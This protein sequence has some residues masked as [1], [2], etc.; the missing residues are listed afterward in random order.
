MRVVYYSHTAFFES[1]LS[2]VREL[3]R[4][5]EVH[6]LIE[7]A[8]TAWRTAFFDL[9]YRRLSPGLAEA[10]TV[11]GAALPASVRDYWRDAASFHFPEARGDHFRRRSRGRRALGR[12]G[13]SPLP[14]LMHAQWNLP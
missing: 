14:M 4:R 2:L 11:L 13:R 1:A 7:L 5:A 12:T 8:P 6:L 9:P 3:S 10:D